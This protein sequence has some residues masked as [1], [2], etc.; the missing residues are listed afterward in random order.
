MTQ[1]ASVDQPDLR[2]PDRFLC[3]VERRA[4]Q[5]ADLALGRRAA[6]LDAVESAMRSFAGR[7]HAHAESTWPALFWNLLDGRL[8]T[9]RAV[10]SIPAPPGPFMQL[11]DGDATAALQAVLRTLTACQRQAF[12]LRVRE[13]LDA[14]TSARV[15]GVSESGLRQQ[16]GQALRDLRTRLRTQP[17]T[18][19]GT[20]AHRDGAWIL[21]SRDLL[22]RAAR[23][24][25][26]ATL[27]RLAMARQ[28]ALTLAP[29]VPPPRGSRWLIRAGG[30]AIVAGVALA[31]PRLLPTMHSAT[32]PSPAVHPPAPPAIAPRIAPSEDTPLAAP[33]FDLL[34]DGDDEAL[35]EDLAF[36][37][38]L[39]EEEQL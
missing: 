3:E 8:G 5:M 11:S 38:W 25:D 9:P 4:L 13:D 17:P 35:L 30:L 19:S 39:A 24:L 15:L 34:L 26:G 21:R 10:A 28:V 18:A 20:D 12:L 14:A 6:A 31:L 27:T 33:D 2:A 23:D 22:D 1:A 29:A 7:F 32:A 37:A 36:Y 16:L